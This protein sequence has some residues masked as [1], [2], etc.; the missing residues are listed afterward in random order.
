[1]NA[2][3]KSSIRNHNKYSLS[4]AIGIT[5]QQNAEMTLQKKAIVFRLNLSSEYPIIGVEKST[6]INKIVTVKEADF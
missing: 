5:T 3:P 6:P 4:I 2:P 1:M